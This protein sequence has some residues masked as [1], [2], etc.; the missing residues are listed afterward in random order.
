MLATQVG[1]DPDE[2]VIDIASIGSHQDEI[3]EISEE[4]ENISALRTR[5]TKKTKKTKKISQLGK[6]P[7]IDLLVEE[8]LA[9]NVEDEINEHNSD[10][11]DNN[12]VIMREYSPPY[13]DNDND[14]W[15]TKRITLKQITKVLTD[16][17][18]LKGGFSLKTMRQL[19]TRYRIKYKL[20]A[21]GIFNRNLR[22]LFLNNL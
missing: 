21:L 4:E 12:D 7:E 2:Q 16:A 13:T 10:N 3:S 15:D 1:V 8:E 20:P 19:F 9:K 18:H 14:I 22:F 17:F 5:K 6:V 11:I